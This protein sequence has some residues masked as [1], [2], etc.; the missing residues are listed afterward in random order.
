MPI[1]PAT[2]A[3]ARRMQYTPQRLAM[4]VI[5]SGT[6]TRLAVLADIHGNLPAL[7]AVLADLAQHPV[8]QV[9]VA[10]DLISWGPFSAAVV[11]HA[12]AEGWATIR[13]NHEI[14]LLDYGT[15]R[16]PV[17]WEDL[18]AF[19]VPRWLHRQLAGPIRDQIALWPDTLSYRPPDAPPLRI[20]HGSPRHH[21]EPIYPGISEENLAPILAGIEEET[22]VA[23][24]THLPM[25][26]Q[27]GRWHVLNPGSVGMML[28]GTLG[29]R[30]LLLDGDA[31]GWRGTFRRVPFSNAALFAEFERQ[32]FAEECGVIGQLIVEEFRTARL[33]IAPFLRWRQATCPD[34]PIS[35]E[36]LARFRTVDPED[37]V[38]LA[39]RLE[40]RQD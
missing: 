11:E 20:V 1:G 40:Q 33:R 26:R 7:E 37:Y 24:H 23:G 3:A 36:T 15:P 2:S 31:V 16:A 34:A 8:D 22:I 6:V 35:A 32:R 4:W 14:M 19:P 5:R 17:A 29:A 28:D 25:D 12:L 9:I 21:S 13:G 39:H 10:G 38:P 27:I 30:Y 18:R